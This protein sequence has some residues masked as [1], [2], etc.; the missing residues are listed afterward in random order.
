MPGKLSISRTL[1]LIKVMI[2]A[3]FVVFSC[4]SCVLPFRD[5][6][7]LK[8]DGI[9]SAEGYG[10]Y[11]VVENGI[12]TRYQFTQSSCFVAAAGYLPQ[13][14]YLSNTSVNDWAELHPI[15]EN[16]LKIRRPQDSHFIELVRVD[17]LP[18]YCNVSLVDT[19]LSQFVVLWETVRERSALFD[20]KQENLES[21]YKKYVN[22]LV[23]LDLVMSLIDDKTTEN[24]LFDTIKEFLVELG[25]GHAFLMSSELERIFTFQQ[26]RR[27]HVV[28]RNYPERL[29]VALKHYIDVESEKPNIK[30]GMTRYGHVYLSVIEMGR[31]RQ[32]DAYGN[33]SMSVLQN[34]LQKA[35]KLSRHSDSIIVDLRLN[36][37]GSLLFSEVIGRF[38]YPES[39]EQPSLFYRAEGGD[40]FIYQRFEKVSETFSHRFNNIIVLLGPR[41]GSA[42]EHLAYGLKAS[43]AMLIGQ[44][45]A[46]IYSPVMVRSLPNGWF[47]GI[48]NHIAIGSHNERLE[49]RG[50]QP[51]LE[52]TTHTKQLKLERDVVLEAAI[53]FL[54]KGSLVK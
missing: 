15:T 40:F 30:L 52:I 9:W 34:I 29:E 48:S 19:A 18:G 39:F 25:D 14:G 11:L 10:F 49:G 51:I 20:A 7:V 23:E 38:L 45:S 1:V 22:R 27:A 44:T 2:L 43:G 42:A 53:Q 6:P 37:G 21:I 35:A 28:P 31:F 16:V 17:S 26:D 13:T 36:E 47:F 3:S 54:N 8:Y 24:I 41:T 5:G 4:V 33:D 50:V 12:F 32:G 46:G